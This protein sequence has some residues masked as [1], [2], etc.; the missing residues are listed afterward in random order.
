MSTFNRV[1][2][3]AAIVVVA[4]PALPGPWD[5]GTPHAWMLGAGFGA[6]AMV[7]AFG[8]RRRARLEARLRDAEARAAAGELGNDKLAEAA[9]ALRDRCDRSALSV[10]FLADVAIRMDTRDPRS[11]S[12]AALELA[13]A[14]TGARGGF[15]QLLE[16][17]ILRTASSRGTWSA[18]HVRPPSVFRDLV[19]T[20]ALCRARPV[21]A[22]EV[23]HVR[24]HDSDLAAPLLDDDGTTLGVV[25][26]RGLPHPVLARTVREDLA[27]IG[28]WAGHAI[29]RT[30][31]R[32]DPPDRSR[33]GVN[34]AAT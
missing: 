24:I 27:A 21:A 22:H 1:L 4:V 13:M 7:G 20:A 30:G 29:A 34:R 11:A 16:D 15:V 9:L 31:A 8:E 2:A 14:R 3:A 26:L 32:M 6:I 17:N 33:D 19:V 25:A 18:E 23:E 5:L 10:A 12:E 28:R